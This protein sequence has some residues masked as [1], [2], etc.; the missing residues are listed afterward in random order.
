MEAYEPTLF[1]KPY[2]LKFFIVLYLDELWKL[3]DSTSKGDPD[4]KKLENEGYGLSWTP[5]N[6]LFFKWSMTQI[7]EHINSL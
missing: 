4:S 5:H 6:R 2:I 3:G 7:A 1:L